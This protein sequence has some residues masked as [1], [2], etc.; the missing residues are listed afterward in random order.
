MAQTNGAAA[1]QQPSAG[2]VQVE[3]QLRNLVE[4]YYAAYQRRDAEAMAAL[5]SAQSPDLGAARKQWETLFATA[6]RIELIGLN[7]SHLEINEDR[8]RLRVQVEL[9][10]YD[11]EDKPFAGG[12]GK[13]YRT[14]EFAREQAGWRIRRLTSTERDLA[15]AIIK[16]KTEAEGLQLLAKEPELASSELLNALLAHAK[17][18]LKKHDYE[19]AM[20]FFNLALKAAEMSGVSYDIAACLTQ[21]ADAYDFQYLY[22]MA[23]AD[24]KRALTLAESIGN[25]DLQSSINA[26]LALVYQ[27]L[28]NPRQAIEYNA[29]ALALSEELG[30]SEEFGNK[31]RLA[32]IIGNMGLISSNL[33][34]VAAQ[35]RYYEQALKLFEELKDPI[36]V[37]ITYHNLGSIYHQA[38]NYARAIELYRKALALV[39]ASGFDDFPSAIW[40]E[41]G[42]NYLKLKDFAAAREAF[43]T[44]K[45]L[46]EEVGARHAIAASLIGLGN[47]EYEQQK[48]LEAEKYYSQAFAVNESAN[49]SN[50]YVENCLGRVHL[51]LGKVTEA[52]KFFE[53]SLADPKFTDESV[54]WEAYT[55]QG[56]AFLLL[57]KP[58]AAERAFQRAIDVIEKQRNRLLGNDNLRQ[59]YFEDKLAPYHQM[60]RLQIERQQPL[61]ALK[62]AQQSTGRTLSEVLAGPRPDLGQWMSREER[63]E[64]QRL[65]MALISATGRLERQKAMPKTDQVKIAGLQEQVAKLQGERE[66]FQ[67]MLLARHEDIARRQGIVSP[68]SLPEVAGLLDEQTVV[69]KYLVTEQ[70]TYLFLF[71]NKE[72]GFA[73]KTIP[74][75][76][77]DLLQKTQLLRQRL[78]NRDVRIQAAAAE[79]FKLLLGPLQ[80]S[81]QG[82]K[83]LIVIPDGPLWELPFQTLRTP[84]SRYLLEDYTISYAPSL[85]A[86]K[87]M[88]KAPPRPTSRFNS[89]L[90][91]GPPPVQAQPQANAFMSGEF[92]PL[93]EAEK[94]VKELGRLLSADVRLGQDAN[95]AFF[96]QE[97]G[98]YR[99]LHFA[100]HG[101]LNDLNPMY[102][103]LR[104]VPTESED[105]LLQSWEVLNLNLNADLAVLAA[106]ETGR[107]RV[108]NGEGL[109]GLSWAF[110]AAGCP[111]TV[112][113]QWEV[114]SSSTTQLM[115]EFYRQL[116]KANQSPSV[117]ESLRQS[118]LKLMRDKRYRHPFFWAGFITVGRR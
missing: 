117:A 54:F 65:Q 2:Q 77:R 13:R 58:D 15:G 111:T 112:V 66:L 63:D 75:Q 98:K 69:L 102:S 95:E 64:E 74:V 31:D 6:A 90:A 47:L 83:H 45:K 12:S 108:G 30:N 52:L 43:S 34:M 22:E 37:A 18:L 100:T 4:T 27:G 106:C 28:G 50:G 35:I 9:N 51:K 26:K 70:A 61:R 33:G 17:E 104:L 14:M 1:F 99:I 40:R 89:L 85:P 67:T 42:H 3:T 72:S 49:R 29:R 19:P 5:W 44:S 91:F 16:A 59:G 107:G 38:N 20:S 55:G 113:S 71:T 109:I 7:M 56:Q 115:M 10:S 96:K 73:V 92:V 105:G 60:I 118:A 36:R 41:L 79:L 94:Q 103:A 87:E 62:V 68:L 97:A 11:K 114:E 24:H 53:S 8:A 81:I 25:K 82:K 84:Q 116:D 21:R 39:P 88:S 46:A 48:W 32:R 101:V 80:N 57:N 93:P 76:H 78:A 86:L 23:L 110:M